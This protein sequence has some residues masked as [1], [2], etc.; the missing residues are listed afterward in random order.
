MLHSG[1]QGVLLVGFGLLS[2]L[3]QRRN[4][5][6]KL[7]TMTVETKLAPGNSMILISRK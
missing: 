4:K 5:K 1:G 7:N 3:V 6:K 2:C